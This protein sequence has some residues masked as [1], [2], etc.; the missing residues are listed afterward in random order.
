MGS[1]V[2]GKGIHI[3][4]Q[5]GSTVKDW[6]AQT[7]AA[8]D[9]QR[10]GT[11]LAVRSGIVPANDK[12]AQRVG[13]NR[14]GSAIGVGLLGSAIGLSSQTPPSAQI[15][16]PVIGPLHGKPSI[17]FLVLSFVV[18]GIAATYIGLQLRTA[19]RTRTW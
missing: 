2:S 6:L 13:V 18:M 10:I 11:I 4:A 17:I 19:L 8:V 7:G 9:L 15:H 12:T 5:L 14:L 1:V 3:A 16:G